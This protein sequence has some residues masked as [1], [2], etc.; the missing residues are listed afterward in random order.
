MR[1][2]LSFVVLALTL[3]LGSPASAQMCGGGQNAS[4]ATNGGMC[5]SMGQRV[6]DDPMADKPAQPSGPV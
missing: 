5:G 1:T 4:S 2:V 3:S 6:A